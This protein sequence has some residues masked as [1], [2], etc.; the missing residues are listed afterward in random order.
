MLVEPAEACPKAIY[1]NLLSSWYPVQ[2]LD[3]GF[4]LSC[5]SHSA[6]SFAILSVCSL[7]SILKLEGSH[8]RAVFRVLK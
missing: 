2:R 7:P 6:Q 5:S 3:D 8:C 1:D 4:Q